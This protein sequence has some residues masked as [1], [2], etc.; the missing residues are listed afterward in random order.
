MSARS[1]ATVEDDGRAPSLGL[2]GHEYA[3][4]D[5]V[6]ANAR[7]FGL[8][9]QA[10]FWFAATCLPAAWFYGALMAGAAGLPGALF[11]ILVVSPL[12]LIPWAFLGWIAAKTGACS[13]ALVRPAFGLRGSAAPSVLYLVFGLGWAAVNVFLGAIGLSFVFAAWLGTPAFLSPGYEGPMAAS[14]VA[15]A[16]LQGIVAAGGHRV[17]RLVQWGATFALLGLGA[18][19]LWLVV[20][21]WDPATLFAWRPPAGGLTTSIGP[22]TYTITVALLVDLL[23]AY[24]WTWEFIGDFSRFARSPAAGTA[25]PF[26]GANAA[27]TWWFGVGALG[28]VFLATTTGGF[29]PEAA[30]PSS[31]TTSLGLGWV[32]AA[33]IIAAT[34]ATNAGNL[35]A[36]ALAIT[37][38]APR[39][40]LGL[41]P[42]IGAVSLAVVPLALVP[43][44][45]TGFQAT[46]ILW[47]DVLGAIVVPL[48]VIVLVDFFWVRRGRYE[49]DLFRTEGGAYWY[50]R[51]WNP[52]GVGV[53]LAGTTLYWLLA[54][55]FPDVREVVPV[56]LPVGLGVALAYAALM[57]GEREL[58]APIAERLAAL[59]EADRA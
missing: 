22:F 58:A 19:Q 10:A 15:V 27:Q 35:T 36:S 9:D 38:L 40:P 8:A 3:A 14:I 57:R 23:I 7:I 16:I 48:W 41:R 47:L 4:L 52:R 59:S 5:P 24:N 30:D 11:L 56:A 42:L 32:A 50:R 21:H 6:P 31:L 54:Y 45:V 26:L 33:V 53:L 28:V 39:L 25:G 49:P 2:I 55:G 13:T 37:N 46:Y 43:I 44:L 12:S 34:V 17:L 18:V 1:A 51:G 29:A 20:T